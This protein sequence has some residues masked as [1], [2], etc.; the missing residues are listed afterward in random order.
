MSI[1]FFVQIAKLRYVENQDINDDLFAL[2]CE[3]N[4]RVRIFSAC[5]VNGVRFH[6][7]N[8]E[9]NRRTQN[10]GIVAEG[11]HDNPSGLWSQS[12]GTEDPSSLVRNRGAALFLFSLFCLLLLFL[13]FCY[14]Y[15]VFS[16]PNFAAFY[17]YMK[18]IS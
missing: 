10:S 14:F 13:V 1:D 12:A 5:L 16:S 8:H 18:P 15:K 4:L 7:V 3:P 9:K 2:S 17:P 6:T 11:T